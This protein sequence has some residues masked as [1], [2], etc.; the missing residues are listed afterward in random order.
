[1]YFTLG[2]DKQQPPTAVHGG[3]HISAARISSDTTC[4]SGCDL[5]SAAGDGLIAQPAAAATDN[6]APH[7]HGNV[8]ADVVVTPQQLPLRNVAPAD[9]AAGTAAA[10]AVDARTVGQSA[11]QQQQQVPAKFTSTL[12]SVFEQGAE[13]PDWTPFATSNSAAAVADTTPRNSFSGE[14][15]Q[16]PT[17]G[18]AAA[19]AGSQGSG[20]SSRHS[21]GSNGLK[22]AAVSAPVQCTEAGRSSSQTAAAGDASQAR[23]QQGRTPLAAARAASAQPPS[24]VQMSLAHLP[25]LAP[26]TR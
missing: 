4:S 16:S 2:L 21:K 6:A 14:D 20:H 25:H 11:E 10:A 17:A 12:P 26:R 19:A 22:T 5:D 13:D 3:S 8:G 7:V 9:T 1:M 24:H 23:D 18:S 15:C